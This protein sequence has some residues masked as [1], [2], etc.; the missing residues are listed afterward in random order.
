M[1]NYVG[2]IVYVY[3][4]TFFNM[5][6]QIVP[7]T[8]GV[9]LDTWDQKFLQQ[10]VNLSSVPLLLG[11]DKKQPGNIMKNIVIIIEL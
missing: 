1:C 3:I 8:N 2:N 11:I 7:I 4:P 9:L 6:F 5:Y 10:M